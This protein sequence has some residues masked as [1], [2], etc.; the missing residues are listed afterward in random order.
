MSDL[1]KHLRKRADQFGMVLC[2]PPR[3]T[4]DNVLLNEAADRIEALERE[5]AWLRLAM[6]PVASVALAAGSVWL[7]TETVDRLPHV[8]SILKLGY[9]R[10]VAAALR[11][12]KERKG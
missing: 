12:A 2:D 9:L 7:D 3:P 1:I 5:N 8:G 6:T 4:T 11:D 10:N